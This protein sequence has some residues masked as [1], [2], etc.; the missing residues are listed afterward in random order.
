[1]EDNLDIMTAITVYNALTA[2]QK[3]HRHRIRPFSPLYWM[4]S[5]LVISLFVFWCFFV[6]WAAYC[7]FPSVF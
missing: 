2:N 7:L 6:S 1:M 3:K 5:M 4:L